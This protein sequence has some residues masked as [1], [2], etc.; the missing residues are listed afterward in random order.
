[1]KILFL[2]RDPFVNMGVMSLSACLK[3]KHSCY[4][5]I[6]NAEQNLMREIKKINPDIIAFSC[7][8]GIHT[9]ALKTA[10]DIKK[11]LKI[12]IIMGGPHPTFFPEVINNEAVDIICM[13]EG[14][15]AIVELLSKLESQENITNINNLY[16]KK[17]EKIYRND[18]SNLIKN[19]DDLPFVDRFIYRRYP[20]IM[21][22]KNLRVMTGRGC[23]YNCTFCFNKSLKEMYKNKGEY[24]RR[25]S[26][27]NV[28]NEIV[29]VRKHFKIKRVDF[30]D[31]TFIYGFETWLKPFLEEY[32]CKVNL[33]F[34]CSVRANLVTL[35]LARALK[36]GGCHS[37][38]MGIESGNE[39][40]NNT[41]LGKNLTREVLMKAVENLKKAN[42]K[43]ETFNIIG[44]PGE[45]IKDAL[46]TLK[47][48]QQL[49]VDFARCSLLQ[50]YPKTEIE[51]Y[52]KQGG[53]LDKNYNLNYF[54]NSYFVDTPIILK[55]KNAFI[56]IQ[57]LFN[58]GVKHPFLLPIIRKAIK[59][60]KNFIF[61]TLFKID[62]ALSIAIMD[63][64]SIID[65]IS[66]G[67]RSKGYFKK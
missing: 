31:D 29:Q 64:I 25:R 40:L 52:A 21:R 61:D 39:Y 4:L 47:F 7:T 18:L 50:P 65:F 27:N 32:R 35:E 15:K 66:F 6:E 38:K 23:P 3:E 9:W 22:Q 34:T 26:I 41:V 24:V 55:D 2:Q 56:N 8:T 45:T 49:K 1:M 62:Y 17:E 19:L 67:M 57:R 10:S 36:K 46:N 30:Q 48:N 12:P 51:M 63:K 44:I 37:V 28:I 11:Q 58:I 13:G 59:F 54:E 33:P 5:L 60:P 20:F 14:E 43:I 53:Y 16:V 42:L